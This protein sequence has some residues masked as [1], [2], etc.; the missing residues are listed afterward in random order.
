[1]SR[2]VTWNDSRIFLNDP[3]NLQ[4]NNKL[5]FYARKKQKV[6]GNFCHQMTKMPDMNKLWWKLYI[7]LFKFFFVFLF[8]SFIHLLIFRIFLSIFDS[9]IWFSLL[10]KHC[11]TNRGRIII[12]FFL[13]TAFY[14]IQ[15]HREYWLIFYSYLQSDW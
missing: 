6:I 2:H 9:H 5:K 3:T 1:M 15:S 13:F 7:H 8:F 11:N 4:R 10:L 14:I 12:H